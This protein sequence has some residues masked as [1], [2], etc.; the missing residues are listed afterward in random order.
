ML[1][2]TPLVNWR[3][4]R[5]LTRPAWLE[6]QVA[7]NFFLLLG[8]QFT[9]CSMTLLSRANNSPTSLQLTTTT[10][11]PAKPAVHFIYHKLTPAKFPALS[12]EQSSASLPASHQSLNRSI[13]LQ[14]KKSLAASSHQTRRAC[15]FGAADAILA[16]LGA[17][18]VWSS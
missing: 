18:F 5:K 14:E 6:P 3:P 7:G 8:A 9:L 4:Q 12:W 15:F 16:A 10:S 17:R 1:L 11:S 2:L 13:V